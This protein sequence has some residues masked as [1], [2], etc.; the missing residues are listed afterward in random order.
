MSGKQSDHV[1]KKTTL[2]SNISRVSIRIVYLQ[3]AYPP[4]SYRVKVRYHYH[5][6]QIC[7][8]IEYVI[9]RCKDEIFFKINLKEKNIQSWLAAQYIQGIH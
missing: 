6:L 1:W 3:K 4:M 5:G 8:V 9:S 2:F 7:G